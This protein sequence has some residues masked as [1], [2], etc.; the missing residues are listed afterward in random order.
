MSDRVEDE[1]RSFVTFALALKPNVTFH[2]KPDSRGPE[3]RLSFE[4]KGGGT[5]SPGYY[6]LEPL[7]ERYRQL[8]PYLDVIARSGEDIANCFPTINFQPNVRYHTIR[9]TEGEFAIAKETA[10]HLAT[11]DN[12]LSSNETAAASAAFERF[13]TFLQVKR[14]Q[15]IGAFEGLQLANPI[16][17]FGAGRVSADGDCTGAVIFVIAEVIIACPLVERAESQV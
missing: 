11:I 16:A 5:S 6:S 17:S 15:M 1:I 8:K 14:D 9:L 12:A 2:R 3:L 4:A 7:M 13:Q 10:M